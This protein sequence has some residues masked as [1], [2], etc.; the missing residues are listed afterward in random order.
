MR[1]AASFENFAHK[2]VELEGNRRLKLL[3]DAQREGLLLDMPVVVEGS[4]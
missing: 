2:A 1:R 3:D 4:P